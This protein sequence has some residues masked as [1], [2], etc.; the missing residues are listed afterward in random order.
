MSYPG[1]K[2]SSC[3]PPKNRINWICGSKIIHKQSANS[4]AIKLKHTINRIAISTF[5][6]L[7]RDDISKVCLA[8]YLVSYNGNIVY[9]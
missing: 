1:L 9:S 3:P 2:F 7:E 4:R 8:T 5:L 6:H